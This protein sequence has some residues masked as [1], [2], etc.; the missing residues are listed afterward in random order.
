MA[1]G[2][3]PDAGQQRSSKIARFI[4]RPQRVIAK[5]LEDF[6][7]LLPKASSSFSPEPE[8]LLQTSSGSLN[9]RS[10]EVSVNEAFRRTHKYLKIGDRVSIGDS[11]LGILQYYGETHFAEG[12]L[13]GIELDDA[14]GGKHSGIVD[15]VVYFTCRP[16]HGI[17][18]PE[19]KVKL[20]VQ[21]SVPTLPELPSP[22]QTENE[23]P[24]VRPK[25][26]SLL[27]RLPKL[28]FSGRASKSRHREIDTTEEVDDAG[29]Y[30]TVCSTEVVSYSAERDAPL[31]KDATVYGSPDSDS[32]DYDRRDPSLRDHVSPEVLQELR[33]ALMSELPPQQPAPEPSAAPKNAL[34][35]IHE[36]SDEVESRCAKKILS[37]SPE[38][39]VGGV[40]FLSPIAEIMD[41]IDEGSK[42]ESLGLLTDGAMRDIAVSVDGQSYQGVLPNSFSVDD[43]ADIMD[44]E[45]LDEVE[46][47]S[48]AASTAFKPS[49]PLT[50]DNIPMIS[51]NVL[52]ILQYNF[53]DQVDYLNTVMARS[54][55]IIT[56]EPS[57]YSQTMSET[58]S[59]ATDESG[60]KRTSD[61]LECSS[62]FATSIG[63]VECELPSA[64]DALTAVNLS[65]LQGEDG[66]RPKRPTSA[67][68][69]HSTD[70]GFQGDSEM[71][72]Q[73]EA[74]TAVSPC[75]EKM[76]RWST[77]SSQDSGAVSESEFQR[78][79]LHPDCCL[80]CGR[81]SSP[82]GKHL[83][84][85][86][87]QVPV[88]KDPMSAV[89]KDEADA[90]QEQS[91]NEVQ[92]DRGEDAGKREEACEE[93]SSP[94]A[95][96]A[97]ASATQNRASEPETEDVNHVGA[98]NAVAESDNTKVAA[99]VGK[100][101]RTTSKRLPV[102]FP[103]PAPKVVVSKVKA[104][105]EAG[106]AE[107]EEV[108]KKIVRQPKKGRW[109][110]VT[111]KLA[112]SMA[113]EK[114]KPKVKEVKSKVFTNLEGA[115]QQVTRP[116]ALPPTLRKPMRSTS[117][118]GSVRTEADALTPTSER[119]HESPGGDSS[120]DD[121][122]ESTTTAHDGSIMKGG[123]AAS[124]HSSGKGAASVKSA[125][126]ERKTKPALKRPDYPRPWNTR[127]PTKELDGSSMSRPAL[128]RRSLQVQ[129]KLPCMPKTVHFSPLPCSP[130]SRRQ[131]AKKG[132]AGAT[133]RVNSQSPGT[134]PPS[135][136]GE[137][138]IQAQTKAEF[139]KEIQRL[140]A[141]CE[142]RTKELTMLKLQLRH[143]SAG[144]A[145]FAV[146]VQHLNA[147]VLQNNSFRIP[148]LSEELRKSQEE[149]EKARI[150]IVEEAHQNELTGYLE[151][152][153]RKLEEMKAFYTNA[154]DNSRKNSDETL[155]AMKQRHREKIDAINEEYSLQLDSINEDHQA[156]Q[157]EL[158]Q[159]YEA[160]QQQHKQLQQQAREFQESV[161]SDTDAKIQWLSKKN[162]DLQKE[163]ESLNVVLE[164]RANQIQ[165]LQHAKIELERKEEELDRCK[166]KMQKME[167]R[168]EDLQ[169][170][171]N[172]KAKVQSQLSVENA[173]LRE[174]SEKQNRQLSRLDMHNEELKYKLR[175]SVSSPMRD[176]GN[177][178]RARSM[179]HK[180]YS[181]ADPTVMSQSWHAADHQSLPRAS[182]GGSR[183]LGGAHGL[184][185]SNQTSHS[186]PRG[187]S[188][189]F[190]PRMR[191]SM[192]ETSPP[193]D[194]CV[195][196]LFT[197]FAADVSNDGSTDESL[198]TFENS[199]CS[200]DDLLRLTW[201]KEDGDILQQDSESPNTPHVDS[202]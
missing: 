33:S 15:G 169:E 171:L 139:T 71:E 98:E 39:A 6:T 18:V 50:N 146:V 87:L 21:Q 4:P 62:G 141:L 53:P 45:Q 161:L 130:A 59:S 11:K 60:L 29:G 80:D 140:G 51:S 14:A 153:T 64:A 20:H 195:Q 145:S 8:P 81:T 38:G 36:N 3:R 181:V 114:A 37:Q 24:A 54:G 79:N 159:R 94:D 138:R 155:D 48:C 44:E 190:Q 110:D 7:S 43:V 115:K 200:Q 106:K 101:E 189:G 32:D 49:D 187:S 185:R 28:G 167:A 124:V 76:M 184:H 134:G 117:S 26:A 42:Q 31:W 46:E 151:A 107:N 69:V 148:K 12:V 135:K 180:R 197:S 57:P 191:R 55:A 136:V 105:I 83:P 27:S 100:V 67:Y 127:P 165:N 95:R 143:A 121:T 61:S 133:T 99:S 147:Q 2:H 89:K 96:P 157:K 41:E 156:R 177:K 137:T 198:S 77:C 72:N 70:T 158:Q 196:Q 170:L 116:T 102:S 173:K 118:R 188:E 34:S 74:G 149:I 193:Q 92:V 179:A 192:S 16:N 122:A 104:M 47:E 172:E 176:G 123:D 129:P 113:D 112:A 40:D 17:F 126:S 85:L 178:A 132:A 88:S 10:A 109:D 162:A 168:I 194:A 108:A 166:V 142:S 201:V 86:R 75:E 30:V 202:S 25:S 56:N 183:L 125:L 13:C 103:R 150:A 91:A 120:K 35:P 78:R 84:P 111:S 9:R 19:S 154:L 199:P 23:Q 58:P 175:E 82:A 97:E 152:H 73:S 174:T 160:L 22:A 182:N 66:T 164:M 5:K 1:E 144:F 63:S 90:D 68:T 93:G 131:D 163:V 186:L 65:S 52:R 128:A 119:H